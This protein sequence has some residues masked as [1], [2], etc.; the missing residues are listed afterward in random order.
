MARE[1]NQARLQR[2]IDEAIEESL[3]LDYKAGV[4]LLKRN[5][6]AREVS[7]DVSAMANAA[8]GIIIY[9][10][11]EHEKKSLQ[12]RPAGFSPVNR[13][14]CSKETLEQ[15]ISSNIQPRISG[16][17]IHPIPLDS[18]PAHVA[19]VVTIPQ[20]DTVHQATKSKRYYKRFN[21]ESVPM[22]DYEVRD[23]LNRSAHPNVEPRIGY[24][25]VEQVRQGWVWSVPIFAKNGALVVATGYDDD[26]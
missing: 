7:K 11:G 9:G 3:I 4:A 17:K 2:Y 24:M 13:R 23:V 16:I 26:G 19:Y 14:E 18:D 15:I 12:H 25:Q 1:W 5:G 22:E 20:S 8:G 6:R 21:F 10:I